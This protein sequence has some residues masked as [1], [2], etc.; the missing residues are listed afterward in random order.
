MRDI[1]IIGS[2]LAGFHATRRL[3]EKLA[4]RRRVRLTVVTRRPRFVFTPLL[5]AVA[6]G[7]LEADHLI[8]PLQEAL[9]ERTRVVVGDVEFIDADAGR[10]QTDAEAISYDYLLV[11]TGSTRSSTAFEGADSLLGP[12]NLDDATAI[13]DHVARICEGAE[14]PPTFAVVGATI[15]GVQWAGQLATHLAVEYDRQCRDGDV[16]IILY[17]ARDRV[18][19]DHSRQLSA[20]VRHDLHQLGVDI[21]TGQPVASAAP[22]SVTLADGTTTSTSLTIHCASRQGTGLAADSGLPTDRA[23]Y[24]SVES[25]LGVAAHPAIFAA[26]DAAAAVGEPAPPSDPHLARQ[27][28]ECAARNLVATMSGRARHDFEFDD[29]GHFITL[30]PDHTVLELAGVQLRGRPAWLAYRLYYMALMPR[31]IR[32]I[33]LLRDWI[34]GRIASRVPELPDDS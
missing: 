16:Q 25:D 28:G 17:E 34:A 20:E 23:G 24:I 8:A 3:E 31:P 32:K 1:A 13:R 9:D 26:G 30:G 19:P 21:R 33:R 27:Q 2:G 22:D 18:L 10:L 11:A 15:T 5:T 14:S 4:G 7:E 12:D 6:T 29:R